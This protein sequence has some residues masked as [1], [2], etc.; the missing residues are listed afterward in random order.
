MAQYSAQKIDP[1]TFEIVRNALDSITDQMGL[2]VRRTA[3]S[4]I[5]KDMGDYTSAIADAEGNI[6]AEGLGISLHMGAIADSM[7]YILAAFPGGFAPGDVIISNDP[8]HGGTHLPDI[9]IVRP[10]F[11][12]GGPLVGFAGI[13]S[14]HADIGGR[15]FGGHGTGS[16]EIFQEGLRLAPLKFYE[17]GRPNPTLHKILELNVR[18]PNDVFGDLS[19]QM[20]GCLTAERE[21]LKLVDKY[22]L[23][24]L[25][26]YM[27]ELADYSER[28]ARQAIRQ[29]PEGTYEF[30]DYLDDDGVSPE[31][32]P[33]RIAVK[34]T[35]HGDSM[36]IDLSDS[37]PQAKSAINALASAVR[38]PAILAVR[39]ALRVDVPLNVGLTRCI[40]LVTKPGTIVHPVFPAPVASR[41]IVSF[42]VL[43]A[44]SGALAQAVPD[45]MTAANEGG[46]CVITMGGYTTEGH[47]YLLKDIVGGS[48]GARPTKDGLEGVSGIIGNVANNS[49]ETEESIHPVRI[50]QYGFVPDSAGA[51][52][53]RGGVA[54]VRDFRFLEED[55]SLFV[56]SDRRK[57]RPWGLAGGQAGAASWNIL[58]PAGTAAPDRPDVPEEVLPTKGE[59]RIRRGD[60]LRVRS[61]GAGGH[62]HPFE[63]DPELVRRDV[64]NELVTVEGARRDYGVVIAADGQVDEAA[65]HR[66]RSG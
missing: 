10:I 44:V 57:F 54:M 9:I 7:P 31:A 11:Q 48:L 34:L 58:N 47:G 50:E 14:H 22:G 43:D 20:A 64:K 37:S 56:R 27:R 23:E 32:E 59:R 33:V 51:G 1:I 66:L 6:V 3:R 17:A 2:T 55:A 49:V 12:P 19:A 25:N 38:A 26:G 5:A 21:Y 24:T 18:V 65:T 4:T 46:V 62:G 8:Y 15:I 35:I 40:E 28:V 29:L 42:R 39:T 30:V 13:L 61:A 53:Y 52:T 16:T 41:A 60:L 63:R 36:T 45:R